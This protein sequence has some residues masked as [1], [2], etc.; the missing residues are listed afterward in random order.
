[1]TSRLKRMGRATRCSGARW[2][3]LCGE[4]M[5]CWCDLDRFGHTA[6]GNYVRTYNCRGAGRPG[7]CIASQAALQAQQAQLPMDIAQGLRYKIARMYTGFISGE[8][9][10]DPR[11]NVH[12]IEIPLPSEWSGGDGRITHMVP[13]PHCWWIVEAPMYAPLSVHIA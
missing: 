9:E 10:K 5:S 12:A 1:M 13:R 7:S 2:V 8:P 11:R 6:T 3:G 4:G